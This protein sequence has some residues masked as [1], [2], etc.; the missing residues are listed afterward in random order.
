MTGLSSAYYRGLIAIVPR[1]FDVLIEGMLLL[2]TSTILFTSNHFMVFLQE[3]TKV[4]PSFTLTNCPLW[5]LTNALSYCSLET[6]PSRPASAYDIYIIRL[7][8][9]SQPSKDLTPPKVEPVCST[10][11]K[12][13]IMRYLHSFRRKPAISKFDRPFIPNHKSSSSISTDVGSAL[14]KTLHRSFRPVHS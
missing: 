13:Y 10:T 6:R 5:T 1:S 8:K 14:H 9:L 4:Y 11:E 12:E 2:V 3:R 7:R